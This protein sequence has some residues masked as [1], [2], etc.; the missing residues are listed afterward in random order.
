MYLISPAEKEVHVSKPPVK[1]AEFDP[2][3]A[4][5]IANSRY[6]QLMASQERIGEPVIED[7]RGSVFSDAG[8]KH[9]LSTLRYCEPNSPLARK[10]HMAWQLPNVDA[11]YRT[12]RWHCD[13]SGDHSTVPVIFGSAPTVIEA[14]KGRFVVPVLRREDTTSLDSSLIAFLLTEDGQAAVN[15]GL[16]SGDLE[17]AEIIPGDVNFFPA[18]TIHRRSPNFPSPIRVVAKNFL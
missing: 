16:E 7:G 8:E 10:P 6:R 14:L 1:L 11:F 3:V 12:M 18:G 2:E 4:L 13:R 15:A 5:S 17:P 9:I